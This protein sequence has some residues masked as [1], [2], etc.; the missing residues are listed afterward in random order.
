[1][2]LPQAFLAHASPGRLRIRIP[3]RRADEAFFGLLAEHFRGRAGI[4]HVL[5]NKETASLLLTGTLDVRE[6]LGLAEREGLFNA[7]SALR[8]P[9]GA[10]DGEPFLRP[11]HDA[12]PGRVRFK[13][14][15]LHG[16][17]DLKSAL[18]RELRGHEGIRSAKAN[19]L[20]GTLLV[21]FDQ[22]L[23]RECISLAVT[24]IL[25]SYR[26]NGNGRRTRTDALTMRA[27]PR[28]APGDKASWAAMP[29]GEHGQAWHTLPLS[30]VMARLDAD[31]A[32]GLTPGEVESRLKQWGRNTLPDPARVTRWEVASRQLV[33]L[34]NALLAVAAGI[35]V[36]TGG[37]ADAVIILG[38]IA[39]NAAIGFSTEWRSEQIMAALK[40]FRS[41]KVRVLRAGRS[42]TVSA[43]GLVPGDVLDLKPG[44]Y[45]GADARVIE[46][47]MLFIDESSLTGESYPAQK[48]QS[49]LRRAN[50]PISERRN[51]LFGG[52]VVTGGE[53]RALVVATGR[54]SEFGRLQAMLMGTASPRPRIEARLAQTSN[55]LIRICIGLCGV[56]FGLGLLRG[57]PLLEM[58]RLSVSL[59]AAAVPEGL[60]AAATVT[61][62][63]GVRRMRRHGTLV[64][65]LPAV[66]TLGSVQI[67][68]LDKTGTITRNEMTITRVLTGDRSYSFP[69][70]QPC[71]ERAGQ[72]GCKDMRLLLTVAVLCNETKI[73]E[74]GNGNGALKLRG[75]PTEAA[76]VRLAMELDINVARLRQSYPLR[77]VKHR[78]QGRLYMETLHSDPQGALFRAVKGGPAE[79]LE[80]CASLRRNG[81][82]EDLREED[83]LAILK[84][85]DSLAGQGLRVLGMAYARG[86]QAAGNGLVWLGMVGMEDPLRQGVP[87]LI[88]T[89][90][91]AGLDTVMITGDQSATAFEVAR[92][93]KL[94]SDKPVDILDST[95]ISEM[96]E[97]MLRALTATTHVFSRVS[98]VHKLRIVQALQAD[99][100][101][102]AMTGDGINDGPALKAADI[103]IAMGGSGTDLARDVAD[104]ILERDD[105]GTIVLAIKDGRTIKTNIRKSVHFFLSTNFSEVLLVLG[106]VALGLPPPLS[107]M[108]LLW[109]NLISD[110]FPGLALSF[111]APEPDVLS[112]KP[113]DPDAPL[114]TRA[115]WWRM[116]LESGT[117]TLAALAA[118][119]W[120]LARYGAGARA[121]TLGFQGLTLGQ[122]LH[123]LVSRSESTTIFKRRGLPRNRYLE[124][125]MG[126]S[127]AAQAS[128]M[129]PPLRSIL[130]TSGLGLADAFVVGTSALLPLVVNELS[131]PGKE[132]RS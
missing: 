27:H 5:G 21:V 96:P 29:A 123:A 69:G 118:Y 107:A 70:G 32:Q 106:S 59:A 94:S 8:Q 65:Q 72:V 132:A 91:A 30:A 42:E 41:P 131:K 93:L 97:D 105:L 87:E 49:V 64:R 24:A 71:A 110:I 85:N 81:R 129:L 14:G 47:H 37:M 50:A 34:P 78:T 10:Q 63:L 82:E 3:E 38:V 73:L 109:I 92:S 23:D 98:P 111:E 100:K 45:V 53:G 80:L 54:R 1:M 101:V 55:Q 77:T 40:R 115:G 22:N 52:T 113:E 56:V 89:L 25:E 9:D 76:F 66:E 84:Q 127:L 90:Q 62:A 16:E 99:G 122:L 75:S 31:R 120:G 7:A 116:G 103:G 124:A 61:F 121:Q 2:T 117:I 46:A 119:L 86:D 19:A 60:P 95:Q 112:R 6:V 39:A 68:C 20:T 13:V 83:R 11:I 130:G 44:M 125:A 58:L 74:A 104:I 48:H 12:V 28:A 57:R 43:E 26:G 79:V 51:M 18:E 36:F 126:G 88:A 108:Q 114:F 17:K 35:S 15:P 102:V 128:T 67:L 33:S 4:E